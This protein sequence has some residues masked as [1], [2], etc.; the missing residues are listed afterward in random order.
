MTEPF[1]IMMLAPVLYLAYLAFPT[2]LLAYDTA[3]RVTAKCRR[4]FKTGQGK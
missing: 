2:V 3:R 1:N 4:L